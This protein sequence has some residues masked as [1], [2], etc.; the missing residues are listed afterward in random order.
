MPAGERARRQSAFRDMPAAWRSQS[1]PPSLTAYEALQPPLYYWL[2]APVARLL[3]GR[4]LAAQV[5]AIRWLSA[6]VASLAIP[7]VYL[8]ARAVFADMR[9]ALGC[10]AMAA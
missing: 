3:G 9:V 5:L 2:M 4:G 8:L 1:G 10:A 6:L 7:L